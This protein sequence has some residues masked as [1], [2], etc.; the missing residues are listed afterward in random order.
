MFLLSISLDIYLRYCNIQ[1][2]TYYLVL[3]RSLTIPSYM[4]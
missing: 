1:Y 2:I 4:M 3:S